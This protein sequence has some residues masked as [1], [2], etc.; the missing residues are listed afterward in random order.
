MFI[1]RYRRVVIWIFRRG[2]L[3]KNFW[4]TRTDKAKKWY[5]WISLVSRKSLKRKRSL[6]LL[7][8]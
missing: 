1:S 3:R 5:L 8:V 7:K 6:F 2:C 4:S